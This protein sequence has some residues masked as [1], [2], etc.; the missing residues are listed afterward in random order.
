MARPV[1]HIVT[2]KTK[3]TVE[4]LTSFGNTQEEIARY[5]GIS[6]DTL[7]RNYKF[8]LENAVLQ[9]NAQVA[10]KLFRK[11]TRDNDLSAQT[12]WLKTRGKWRTADKNDAAT[13]DSLV[14]KLLEKI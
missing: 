9:A 3:N 4:S 6:V 10:A 7:T 2:D 11:A 12:F 13:M 14:Q 8:E 1:E 5:L